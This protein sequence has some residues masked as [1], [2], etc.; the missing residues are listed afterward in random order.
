M[1]LVS[2]GVAAA[3]TSF[4]SSHDDAPSDA[5]VTASD[6]STATDGAVPEGASTAEPKRCSRFQ[7][8]SPE[9]ALVEEGPDAKIEHGIDDAERVVMR[10][11]ASKQSNAALVHQLP[12]GE[13][14][15]EVTAKIARG[16]APVG[17]QPKFIEISCAAPSVS[18]FVFL[19]QQKL[20]LGTSD[21]FISD[22]FADVPASVLGAWTTFSLRI[23]GPTVTLRVGEGPAQAK[24]RTSFAEAS[25]CQLAIGVQNGTGAL[26][27]SAPRFE[28]SF[29]SVCFE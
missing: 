1:L 11:H 19:D 27:S 24:A 20:R 4:G 16:D 3:C 29:E 17:T 6:A 26:S 25:G 14:A 23:D 15:V 12:S 10:A 7:S 5:S 8:A 9:W 21:G 13:T 22:G 2:P 28:A 18:A